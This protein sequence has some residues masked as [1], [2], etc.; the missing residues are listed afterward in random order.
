M[1]SVFLQVSNTK[2]RL[3]RK[4]QAGSGSV[5]QEMGSDSFDLNI[6]AAGQ[7]KSFQ[8]FDSS[9]CEVMDIEQSVVYPNLEVLHRLLVN[10]RTADHAEFADSSRQGDR[11]ADASAR[12]FA[13]FADLDG[14]L[15]QNPVIISPY[16]NSYCWQST[17]IL[18]LKKIVSRLKAGTL[19]FSL[20]RRPSRWFPRQPFDRLRGS[21][22][23]NHVP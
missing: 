5:N 20:I 22:T 18:S 10:V 17:H 15:I 14:R 4:S 12:A 19:G 3:T 16:S 8:S 9:V 11:S 13:R 1:R 21:Q 23:W 6:Y 7:I 2:T